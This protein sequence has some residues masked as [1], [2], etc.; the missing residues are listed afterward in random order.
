MQP[1]PAELHGS[2]PEEMISILVC[3]R[4]RFLDLPQSL[5]PLS[6]EY[7]IQLLHVFP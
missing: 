3:H 7:K 4:E 5:A 6:Q 1:G 2:R